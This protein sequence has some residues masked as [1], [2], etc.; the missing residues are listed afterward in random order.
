[1]KRYDEMLRSKRWTGRVDIGA[2]IFCNVFCVVLQVDVK[3]VLIAFFKP[4][5]RKLRLAGNDVRIPA[6]S[7]KAIS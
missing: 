7:G 4:S 5:P 6:R 1:M 2:T 3:L